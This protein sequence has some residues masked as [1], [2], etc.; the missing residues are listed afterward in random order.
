MSIRWSRH[1]NF[2]IVAG[3]A[4]AAPACSCGDD[5]DTGDRPDAR[6]QADSAP[7]IDAAPEG[8]LRSGTIAVTEA[9]ITNP[10]LDTFSG[11]LVRVLF[12]DT[13]TGSPPAPAAGFESNINGCLIQVW[14]VGT[15]EAADQVEEGALVVTGTENG[16]FGCGFVSADVGYACRSA[17]PDIAGGTAGNGE[18]MTLTG[19]GDTFEMVGFDVSATMAGMY[20]RLDG[21]APVPDGTMIPILAADEATDTL[22]LF[23]VNDALTVTGTATATFSTLVGVGPVP[24]GAQF[25]LGAADEINISK[26]AGDIVGAIDE[27]FAAHG[28]GY[29]LVDDADMDK[30]L[31]HTIPFDGSEVN[32]ACEAAGCGAAGDGGVIEAVVIN[33]QTTDGEITGPINPASPLPPPVDSYAT[34]TCSFIGQNTATLSA[35]AMAV[36]LGTNPTRIQTSVGRYKGTIIAAEDGTSQVVVVQGHSLLGFS[37]APPK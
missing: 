35:D 26:T 22:T 34:F 6:V 30:Y 29:T 25:L 24:G 36:I 13:H 12:S 32:F 19:D 3:L 2:L 7:D 4:L 1:F 8:L 10:G 16:D 23:G 37:D 9:A 27:D 11:A 14:D 17:N 33:G 15:N 18:G 28:Q 5:D 31:P 20:L 21:F